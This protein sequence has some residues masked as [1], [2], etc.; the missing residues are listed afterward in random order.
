M[1]SPPIRLARDLRLPIDAVTRTFGVVGQRGT[2]KTSTAVVLVEEIAPHA[3]FVVIDPTGAWYGLRSSDDGK[4]AGLDVVV[5]GG[6]EGDVPLEDTSGPLVAD[7]VLRD[8]YSLVLD[9][10]LM[11]KGRQVRFIA[12]FLEALYHGSRE[13]THVVIDEAQRFAPQQTR[14][15]GGDLPRAL[16]A[17]ED[18]VKLG[19]RKGLGAT[20]ISQRSA[21]L[22]KEVLE[23]TETL[24]VHRL[25]GP[26]D[27]KAIAE[28]FE[29]QGSP[30]DEK[31]DDPKELRRQIRGLEKQVREQP[32][33]EPERVEVPVLSE[34]HRH[35]LR[36]LVESTSGVASQLAGV[37]RSI[38]E[39]LAKLNGGQAS[40]ARPPAPARDVAQRPVPVRRPPAPPRQPQPSDDLSL[41]KGA[42]S[43]LE[44][45]ARHH[46][47]K[48]TRAQ[49]GTLT[50]YSH[51]GGTF[52]KYFS[53]LKRAGL[54][55][56]AGS[57][58]AVTDA[59]LDYVGEVP[60]APQTTEELLEVWRG[61][62][63]G[64]ARTLLDIL[65]GQ[66]PDWITREDLGELGGYEASGGTFQKYVGLLKRNGL[67]EVAGPE[68]R[69][70]ETLFMVGAAA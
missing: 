3:P 63:V 52:Q 28:W 8:R 4:G 37:A 14:G 12:D 16:G 18:V 31:A 20:V 42:R 40:R 56:E 29:A 61:S 53:I 24:I 59:G 30:A 47:M 48:V 54:I 17:M 19:R 62:L 26:R 38:N 58:V 70:S 67:V 2:G 44:T 51:R 6:H 69:A 23:Q 57:D 34:E 35:E 32:A 60:E 66:Y 55:E 27:R 49:L 64:G 65:V 50:G 5:L 15:I 22:N 68:L 25:T 45:L 10:E 33:P 46:P 43:I 13:A 7:L 21:S 9:L 11:R 39:R 41:V 1:T 36:K